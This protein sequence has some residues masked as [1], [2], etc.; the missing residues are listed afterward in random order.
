MQERS[1]ALG[2]TGSVPMFG[3][4]VGSRIDLVDDGDLRSDRGPKA[5]SRSGDS[6]RPGV[7]HALGAGARLWDRSLPT[8]DR[9]WNH[10]DS[11]DDA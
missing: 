7:R 8:T 3:E 10:V 9:P 4:Q 5:V 11:L 2:G 6:E 1:K